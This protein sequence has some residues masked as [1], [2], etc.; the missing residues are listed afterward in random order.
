MTFVIEDFNHITRYNAFASNILLAGYA[1]FCLCS[2]LQ[3]EQMRKEKDRRMD[4]VVR[5]TSEI[6]GQI[7]IMRL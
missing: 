2:C 1:S 6:F 4:K 3:P 7:R 5:S